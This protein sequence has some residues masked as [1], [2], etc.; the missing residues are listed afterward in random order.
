MKKSPSQD[1]ENSSTAL[2]S[3]EALKAAS[4]NVFE[5]TLRARNERASRPIARAVRAPSR[6]RPT[7]KINGWFRCHDTVYGPI[8]IFNPKNEGGFSDEPVFVM[9]DLADEL[10]AEGSQFENAIKEVMG[11]L[12]YTVGGALCQ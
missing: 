7:T 10:L 4:E 1:T 2:E 9:P 8:S 5:L 12:A 6:I 11:Y 3:G